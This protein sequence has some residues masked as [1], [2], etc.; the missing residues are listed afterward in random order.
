[1]IS[2]RCLDK[3]DEDRADGCTKRERRRDEMFT[4][5]MELVLRD[6]TNS[7]SLEGS[8]MS[9]VRAVYSLLRGRCGTGGRNCGVVCHAKNVG[10]CLAEPDGY[11]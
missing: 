6:W 11:E 5:I 9:L 7:E 2:E 8:W 10:L 3:D 1:M 4:L